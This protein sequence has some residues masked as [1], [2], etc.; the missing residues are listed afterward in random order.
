MSEKHGGKHNHAPDNTKPPSNLHTKA[1][2][3]GDT[4]SKGC[5]DT[6]PKTENQ[7]KAEV[8]KGETRQDKI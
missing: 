7:L 3:K 8:E 4:K 6:Q 1:W 5:T 2:D